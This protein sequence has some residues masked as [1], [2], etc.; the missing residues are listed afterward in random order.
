ILIGVGRWGTLDPWLGI[1]VKY[2]QISGARVIVEAGLRDIAVSPSQGSHFFQN[3]T[4]FMV[5]YF[6]VHRDGFVDWDWIRKVRA[7]EETE[8][9]KRLHFNTPLIVKMNGHLNKGIILKP[10]S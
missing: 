4:S 3:I 2:D 7:V 8:F 6:T 9:V 10:Q 5:G 1:P